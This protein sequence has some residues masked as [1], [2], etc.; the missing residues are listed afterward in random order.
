MVSE[1][2]VGTTVAG[3]ARSL[4]SGAGDGAG[5]AGVKARTARGLFCFDRSDSALNNERI[6]VFKFRYALSSPGRSVC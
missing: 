5:R 3:C 2:V 6:D 1:V 4:D